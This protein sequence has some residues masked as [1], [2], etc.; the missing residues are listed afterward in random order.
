MN[1]QVDNGLA[2][3]MGNGKYQVRRNAATNAG[4]TQWQ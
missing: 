4:E 1:W 2:K 3:S